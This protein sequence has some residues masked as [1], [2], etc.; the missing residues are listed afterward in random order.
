MGK[1]SLRQVWCSV[2]QEAQ[3]FPTWDYL[4]PGEAKEHGD[5]WPQL[6]NASATAWQAPHVQKP[7]A[8]SR[9]CHVS[10][11]LCVC[12]AQRRSHCGGI[13]GVRSFKRQKRLSTAL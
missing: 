2:G 12:L 6:R 10:I 7:V 8:S 1:T 9:R 11:S 13:F 4:S 5:I 3:S